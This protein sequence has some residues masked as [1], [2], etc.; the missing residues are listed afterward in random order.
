M[1]L[2]CKNY[3]PVM[4]RAFGRVS[5]SV[6]DISNFEDIIAT[7]R[8]EN[9]EL[10]KKNNEL[11]AQ[12]SYE[13]E[14]NRNNVMQADE[15]I[16]E[17]EAENAK[18]NES[19]ESW[20]DNCQDLENIRLNLDEEIKQLREENKKLEE[21]IK[22]REGLSKAAFNITREMRNAIGRYIEI[23][24]VFHTPLCHED[25]DEF[26]KRTKWLVYALGEDVEDP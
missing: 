2:G 19:R 13:Q 14:R 21:E 11:K 5:E 1:N 7:L 18:L 24:M 23:P 25:L 16:K 10:R 15:H 17:L 8:I 4:R 9:D 22:F 6:C 12:V 26:Y 3:N 20:K